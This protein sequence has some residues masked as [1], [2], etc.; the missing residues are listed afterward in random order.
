[1]GLHKLRLVDPPG[2]PALQ[3]MEADRQL[4]TI[5]SID[6]KKPQEQ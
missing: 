1:M 4:R 6:Y 3:E 5:Q 2:V